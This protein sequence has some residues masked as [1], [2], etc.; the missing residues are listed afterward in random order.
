MGVE[1]FANNQAAAGQR[2]AK[3]SRVLLAARLETPSGEVEA[4]L[5]DLSRKGALVECAALVPAI[6]AE[7]VFI[8]GKI[9][10]EARVAWAA[11]NRVGLEFHQA[12]DAAELLVHLGKSAQVQPQTYRRPALTG[13]MN[14]QERKLAKAWSVAVGLNLPEK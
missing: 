9:R 13:S 3:R 5:R 7:V 4:R 12:I 8:R 14:A 6:G 10:I 11:G 1:T 2:S